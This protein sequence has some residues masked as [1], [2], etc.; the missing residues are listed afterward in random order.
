M[1]ESCLPWLEEQVNRTRKLVEEARD[2]YTIWCLSK[3]ITEY[4]DAIL[5]FA[6]RNEHNQYRAISLQINHTGNYVDL[7]AQQRACAF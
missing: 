7:D 4:E 5:C 3:L 1:P 2:P 6:Q